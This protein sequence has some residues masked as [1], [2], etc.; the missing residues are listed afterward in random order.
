ME[1]E[2]A[3]FN[4]ATAVWSGT[5]K[6]GQG[7]L[8]LPKANA[9]FP[10]DFGSRFETGD[11][12]NPEELIAGALTSCFSMYLTALFSSD[13]LT[14]TNVSSTATV[15]LD[16]E[17]SPPKI[18]TI[19]LSVEAKAATISNERFHELLEKTELEC[20]IKNLLQGATISVK[21]AKLIPG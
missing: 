6:E 13:G 21:S 9:T 19:E 14:N 3:K 17:Q 4:S 8:D 18:T 15:T 7:Q 1:D 20:P 12:T 5:L 2:M 11:T 10:Y 16:N